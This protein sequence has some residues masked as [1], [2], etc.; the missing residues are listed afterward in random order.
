MQEQAKNKCRQLSHEEK[1][2]KIEYGR[3]RYQIMSKKDKQRLKEYQKKLS[4]S[5][6][7]NNKKSTFFSL[8]SM[9]MEKKV[10]IFGE[11][12]VIKNSF[13][14]SKQRINID[15]VGIKRIVFSSKE[16]YGKRG[17]FKYFIGYISIVGFL[18]LYMMLP[19]M[20]SYVKYFDSNN[21]HMNVLVNDKE[22]LKN[23][24]WYGIR[25]AIY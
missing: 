18:A 25:L 22:L 6:K 1:N 5:K 19:L 4:W 15:K 21:K 9:K 24:I 20:N 16:S 7:I 12:G 10:L 8:N 13:H 17:V 23:T 11:K 3:S 14:K 2:I